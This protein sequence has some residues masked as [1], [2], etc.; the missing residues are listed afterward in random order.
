VIPRVWAEYL[1]LSP[2]PHPLFLTLDRD[3]VKGNTELKGE[4]KTQISSQESE[5]RRPSQ[6]ESLRA[7]MEKRELREDPHI[8]NANSTITIS[9]MGTGA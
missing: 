9:P 4:N 5:T 2:H 3:A 6:L 1:T 7:I 8:R